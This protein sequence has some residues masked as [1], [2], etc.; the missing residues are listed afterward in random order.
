MITT[1]GTVLPT[2]K[3]L[4]RDKVHASRIAAEQA[5]IG[6]ALVGCH[7]KWAGGEVRYY[8]DGTTYAVV[9]RSLQ[10]RW[11]EVR[12]DGD[13]PVAAPPQEI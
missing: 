9:S 3:S 8:R 6:G 10:V 13:Y 2:A 11:F 12:N 1:L 5:K 4:A 7:A